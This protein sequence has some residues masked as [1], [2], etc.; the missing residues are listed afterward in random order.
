M[1]R[2]SKTDETVFNAHSHA[3]LCRVGC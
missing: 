3:K 1:R 2:P